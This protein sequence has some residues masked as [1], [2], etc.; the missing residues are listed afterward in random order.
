MSCVGGRCRRLTWLATGAPAGCSPGGGPC[1]CRGPTG[2]WMD[3]WMD[4][5]ISCPGE[6]PP[7]GGSGSRRGRLPPERL[8][9][10]QAHG[11]RVGRGLR[12]VSPVQPP[13]A[14]EGPGSS[15]PRVP[16]YKKCNGDGPLGACTLLQAPGVD[17]VPVGDRWVEEE[18]EE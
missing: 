7:R 8:K 3:G 11:T 6:L 14:T 13:C 9:V 18:E 16:L 1:P 15:R 4:H 12:S 2:Q 5:H 10:H 17:P